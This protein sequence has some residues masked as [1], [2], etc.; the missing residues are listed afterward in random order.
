MAQKLDQLTSGRNA[1]GRIQA[2]KEFSRK[3]LSR[4]DIR[5][6]IDLYDSESSSMVQREI[7]STIGR[8]RDKNNIT[9]LINLSKSRDP[10]LI[11]Q[12]L[13]GLSYFDSAKIVKNRINALKSHKNET[14][15]EYIATK[16]A[17]APP[18]QCQ[19]PVA[20]R[21]HIKTG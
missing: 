21:P 14:I 8:Q 15:R 7:I 5:D 2:V 10:K 13:R 9:I 3:N 18:P 6:L 16:F 11:L 12:A 4:R 19:N 1:A 17:T 20:I